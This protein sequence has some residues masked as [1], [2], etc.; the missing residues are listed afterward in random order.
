LQRRE[1]QSPDQA[2]TAEDD[3]QDE[4]KQRR[5][6]RPRDD[7]RG[8]RDIGRGV[9]TLHEE[10]IDAGARDVEVSNRNARGRDA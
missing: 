5:T 9:D 3:R 1:H 10:P 7:Q 8:V 4:A 2:E 6:E